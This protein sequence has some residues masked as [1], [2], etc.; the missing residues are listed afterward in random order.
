MPKAMLALFRRPKSRDADCDADK[1]ATH[2]DSSTTT[3]YMIMTCTRTCTRVP[4]MDRPVQCTVPALALGLGTTD[5]YRICS[6]DPEVRFCLYD[7]ICF[8]YPQGRRAS[9]RDYSLVDNY[10]TD[11]CPSISSEMRYDPATGFVD[12]DDIHPMRMKRSANGLWYKCIVLVQYFS[13]SRFQ[14]V[15]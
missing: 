2:Q 3:R 14:H 10:R 9:S 15:H 12:P 5:Q 7:R 13:N 4:Y 11:L 6:A 1:M 8:A